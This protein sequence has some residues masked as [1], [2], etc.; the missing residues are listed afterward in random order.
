MNY[1]STQQSH[2]ATGRQTDRQAEKQTNRQTDKHASK[3]KTKAKQGKANKRKQASQQAS[4]TNPSR[5]DQNITQA[6]ITSQTIATAPAALLPTQAWQ[7]AT[8][9]ARAKTLSPSHASRLIQE[10][11]SKTQVCGRGLASTSA[12]LSLSLSRW[13]HM[14]PWVKIRTPSAHPNPRY[15]LKWVMH[16]PQHGIPK[17]F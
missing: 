11:L 4:N 12:I 15:R 14:W 7:A 10:P 6:S 2:K 3:A 5:L 8:C 17:R 13:G 16:L 1:C 9:L